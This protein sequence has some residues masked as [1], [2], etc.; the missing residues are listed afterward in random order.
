M[1]ANI[2][3]QVLFVLIIVLLAEAANG[4]TD[5]PTG[6]SAAVASGVLSPRQALMLTS[7]GNFVG[8]ILALVTGAKVAETI[9]TGIVRPD[10]VSVGSIGIAMAT[11]VLWAVVAWWFRFPIRMLPS[12]RA[13]P[14]LLPGT[15]SAGSTTVTGIR[16]QSRDC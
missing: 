15:V 16:R 14:S 5:A 6:T 13:A 9:G 2:A 11:T 12:Q 8:L 7:L 10:V 1:L 4:F 3:P